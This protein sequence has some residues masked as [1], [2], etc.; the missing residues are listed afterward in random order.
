MAYP[1]LQQ[2]KSYETFVNGIKS[3]FT[4]QSYSESLIKYMEFVKADNPDELITRVAGSPTLNEIDKKRAVESSLKEW[5]FHMKKKQK[6]NNI[7][8]TS[9]RRY[10]HGVA[11]FYT[12]NDVVELINFKKLWRFLPENHRAIE[13]RAYTTE[14]IQ[15]LL[16]SADER[17]KVIVLLMESAG[18][19][20]G[21]LEGLMLCDL[22]PVEDFY[23]IKVYSKY[24]DS[25][26]ETFCTP[27]CRKA[28][29]NYIALRQ[30]L[31]EPI[32]KY[33]TPLLRKEFDISDKQACANPKPLKRNGIL[34]AMWRHAY[35]NGIRNPIKQQQQ[36]QRGGKVRTEVYLNH[37]LRKYFKT[38]CEL[39]G[40]KAMVIEELMS[41][42]TGL[43]GKYFRP[44][45]NEKLQEYKKAISDLTINEENKLR[46]QVEEEKTN[47]QK[48]LEKITAEIDSIKEA[49]A[50]VI[51]KGEVK[52][53]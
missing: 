25:K 48:Q 12:I 40:V 37:G 28:I 6:G 9:I 38:K 36:G 21:A 26:Y 8:A 51:A 44:T 42:T 18:L 1:H 24:P 47:S 32:S 39:A 31:G 5:I 10:V 41:H 23:K 22:E 50:R 35:R 29:D 53:L 13:D 34:R 20:V 52:P 7:S 49:M 3:K 15:K 33:S 45:D 2:S 43:A 19:R 11:S 14:E 4:R 27:E 46:L 17:T 30:R 16:E